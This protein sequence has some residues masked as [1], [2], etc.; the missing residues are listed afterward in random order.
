M[1]VSSLATPEGD[2]DEYLLLNVNRWRGQMQVP[3]LKPDE[4]DEK[5]RRFDLEGFTAWFVLIDGWSL[6]MGTLAQSFFR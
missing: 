1:T 6:V 2:F 5:M 4:L 3:P